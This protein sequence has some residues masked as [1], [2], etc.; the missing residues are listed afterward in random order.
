MFY[1][2]KTVMFGLWWSACMLMFTCINYLLFLL[3]F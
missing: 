3:W 1:V 2:F